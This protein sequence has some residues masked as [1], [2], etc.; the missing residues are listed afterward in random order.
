MVKLVGDQI[1]VYELDGLV[2]GEALEVV[3]GDLVESVA[4]FDGVGDIGVGNGDGGVGGIAGAGE[5]DEEVLAGDEGGCWGGDVARFGD[6]EAADL[7]RSPTAARSRKSGER[8][9]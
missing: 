4:G 5:G 8:A 1:R 2:G 7:E 3:G 9:L 6:H